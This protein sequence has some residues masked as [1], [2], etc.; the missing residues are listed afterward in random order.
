MPR[1]RRPPHRI[2]NQRKIRHAAFRSLLSIGTKISPT[3]Y[4]MLIKPDTQG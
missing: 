3:T 2:F 1:I 4:D